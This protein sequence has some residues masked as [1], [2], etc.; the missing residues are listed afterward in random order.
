MLLLELWN[1]GEVSIPPLHKLELFYRIECFFHLTVAK[2]LECSHLDIKFRSPAL[3]QYALKVLT[4]MWLC[5]A[6]YT[7]GHNKVASYPAGGPGNEA[8]NKVWGAI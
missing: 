3:A 2:L 4:L 7:C 1:E 5:P 6:L 8:N